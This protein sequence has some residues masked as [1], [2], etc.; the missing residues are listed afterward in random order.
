[1]VQKWMNKYNLLP[2][3]YRIEEPPGTYG[4]TIAELWWDIGT[5]LVHKQLLDFGTKDKLSLLDSGKCG[6]CIHRS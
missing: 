3:L 4:G 6:D 5:G 1:M 2:S